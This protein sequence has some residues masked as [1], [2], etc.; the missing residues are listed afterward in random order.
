MGLPF[1]KYWQ[2]KPEGTLAKAAL[3]KNSDCDGEIQRMF[4]HS[5]CAEIQWCDG[6]GLGVALVKSRVVATG[7]L[8][9]K[10]YAF[11]HDCI[12][13]ASDLRNDEKFR[14]AAIEATQDFRDLL[15]DVASRD[16]ENQE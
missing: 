3:C 9:H 1:D 8:K 7:S 14:E 16:P 2:D 4:S 10:P 15:Y 6:C 5:D 12:Y 11:L 13:N